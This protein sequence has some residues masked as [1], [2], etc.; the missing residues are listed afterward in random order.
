MKRPVRTVLAALAAAALTFSGTGVALAQTADVTASPA[1]IQVGGTSTITAAGLGNLES[2]TFGL[3]ATPGGLLMVEGGPASTSVKAAVVNGRATVEFSA[4]EAGTFTVAVS[5]GETPVGTTTITVTGAESGGGATTVATVSASPADIDTGST[6]SITADGLGNIRTAT[7]GLDK[8]TGATLSI[9]NGEPSASVDVTVSNGQATA[10]FTATAAGTY[11]VVVTDGETVLGSTTVT[12]AEA[13]P[14]EPTPAVTPTANTDNANTG[15]IV[16]VVV[17]A[18][19]VIAAAIVIVVIVRRRRA[20]A[21]G[22]IRSTR[23]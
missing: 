7:F 19:V 2:A 4:T 14:V 16:A 15:L 22:P 20:G 3:D 23:D 12:V 9:T 11:T 5:D 21:R 13:S 18:L 17:I 8:S 6:A 1:T 10:E